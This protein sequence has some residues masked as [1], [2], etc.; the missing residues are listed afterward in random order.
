MLL[1]Q[2]LDPVRILICF[3][4][5]K[6]M[7]LSE[8]QKRIE[9]AV[10][11]AGLGERETTPFLRLKVV[12]LMKKGQEECNPLKGL[13]TIWNPTQKQVFFSR[14]FMTNVILRMKYC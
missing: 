9:K 8:I 11:D 2:W 4:V 14:C 3:Y 12:G 13:V 1:T 7:R 6:A 10:Q 5:I